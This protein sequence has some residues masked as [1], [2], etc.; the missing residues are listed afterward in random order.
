MPITDE[1]RRVAN[2]LEIL[3]TRR[4]LKLRDHHLHEGD[5]RLTPAKTRKIALEAKAIRHALADATC[6]PYSVSSM[7]EAWRRIKEFEKDWHDYQSYL[8][9]RDCNV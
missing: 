6:H 9:E 3:E 1:G 7:S 2:R 8:K 5:W 4:L